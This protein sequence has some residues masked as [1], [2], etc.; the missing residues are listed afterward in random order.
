[1]VYAAGPGKQAGRHE[2]CGLRFLTAGAGGR[3]WAPPGMDLSVDEP[4]RLL[5]PQEWDFFAKAF[6]ISIRTMPA[7]SMAPAPT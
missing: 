1:M 4:V 2:D 6:P 7:T 5:P 3:R